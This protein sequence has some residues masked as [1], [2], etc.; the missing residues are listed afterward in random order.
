MPPALQRLDLV[1][2]PARLLLGIPQPAH[3]DLV[4]GIGTGPQGLAEAAAVVRDDTDGGGEDLRGRAVILF[5]PDD[6]RS[7]EIAL[8]FEDVAN[9][10][11]APAVDRL[12]VVADAA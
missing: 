6:Q 8:E 9:L 2:N 4:A 7:R 3:R 11:A 1:A 10:G 5:E 12:I